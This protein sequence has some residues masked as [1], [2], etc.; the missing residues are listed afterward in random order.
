[1]TLTHAGIREPYNYLI[2]A[3]TIWNRLVPGE[4][5]R[6]AYEDATED[7]PSTVRYD[8]PKYAK[9]RFAKPPDWKYSKILDEN[10][11]FGEG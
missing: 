10:R 9:A 7:S 5:D 8:Y 11:H 1:M 2:H 6:A 3:T 4:D